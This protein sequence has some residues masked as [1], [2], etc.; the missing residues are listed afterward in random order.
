MDAFSP[1]NQGIWSQLV[2]NYY[3]M[4]QEFDDQLFCSLLSEEQK[5]TYLNNLDI[6][7]GSV[8]PYSDEDLECI[9]RKMEDM[10][11]KVSN[12]NLSMVI[13]STNNMELKKKKLAEKFENKKKSMSNRRK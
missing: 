5:T 6:L 11:Y 3:M 12:Q 8:E 1:V 2:N 4:Y 13:E 9:L 7:R 10:H